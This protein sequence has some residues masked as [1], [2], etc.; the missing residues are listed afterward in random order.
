M[1]IVWLLVGLA[2]KIYDAILDLQGLSWQTNAAL[3]V[4]LTAV[5]RSADDV[6]IFARIAHDVA[7][8]HLVNLLEIL[9]L[10]QRI[11]LSHVLGKSVLIQNLLTESIHH[12]VVILCLIALFIHQSIARRI[13]EHHDIVELHIAQS[14]HTTVIPVRPFAVALHVD[15]R[16]GVL[17][18]RHGEWR[19]RNT[20]TVAH[21]AHEKIVAREKALLER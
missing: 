13:V 11:H 5:G 2:I 9:A 12:L 20:W 16:H 4:V 14:L 6:A 1:H 3:H 10:L 17:G 15:Q 21:L 19:L 7:S 8:A 18:E